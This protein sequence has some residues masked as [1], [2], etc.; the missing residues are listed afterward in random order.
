MWRKSFYI[1]PCPLFSPFKILLP[2]SSFFSCAQTP[3]G[4]LLQALLSMPRGL[5]P[6]P[7]SCL[8]I[9]A[10]CPLFWTELY[11]RKQEMNEWSMYL[12]SNICCFGYGVWFRVSIREFKETKSFI[13]LNKFMHWYTIYL[14]WH[15][16]YLEQWA[17]WVRQYFLF[18]LS[19]HVYKQKHSVW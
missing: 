11:Q 17:F 2:S 15:F 14:L 4:L 13:F 19:S 5:R 3:E 18:F 16:Y 6:H 7:C 12:T 10:D 1:L 8:L 9:I